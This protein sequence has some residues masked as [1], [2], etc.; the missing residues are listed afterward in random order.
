[1]CTLQRG[2]G[3]RVYVYVCI[4]KYMFIYL[5]ICLFVHLFFIYIIH[6]YIY[7]HTYTYI[8]VFFRVRVGVSLSVSMLLSRNMPSMFRSPHE[9]TFPNPTRP[10]DVEDAPAVDPRDPSERTRQA[11]ITGCLGFMGS[12]LGLGFIAWGTSAVVF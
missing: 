4:Y 2:F 12:A 1:M 6:I 11:T 5:F 9:L 8:H 10:Q 3:F 7:T